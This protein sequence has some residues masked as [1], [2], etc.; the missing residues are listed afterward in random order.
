MKRRGV[1]VMRRGES[2]VG[3]VGGCRENESGNERCESGEEGGGGSWEWLDVQEVRGCVCDELREGERRW[4]GRR[5]ASE[6]QS[7]CG[8]NSTDTEVVVD[9]RS[10]RCE[11]WENFLSR[12]DDLYLAGREKHTDL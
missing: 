7:C 10:K 9:S 8:V 4:R 1:R 12:T 11:W 5:C 6:E 2:E 3:E